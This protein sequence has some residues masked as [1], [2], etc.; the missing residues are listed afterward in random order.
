MN[1]SPREIVQKTLQFHYP[2]RIARDLWLL[3]VAAQQYPE[4][5]KWLQEKYPSDFT[6]SGY[7]YPPSSQVKGDPHKKG[8]FRDEWGCEFLNLQEGIIGEVKHPLISDIAD[9][10]KVSP[11]YEQLPEGNELQRAYDIITR[12]YDKTDNFMMANICPRPWERYQFLRGSQ[13]SYLDLLFPQ[14]GFEKLLKRINDFYLR[15]LEIWVKAKVDGISFMDDWGAQSTLLI[16]PE[17]WRHYFK[18]IY[19]QYCQMAKA[20]GKFVFMHSDGYIQDILPD[21]VEIGVDAV[22]SQLFCMDIDEIAQSVKGK[23]T[24]WGEIDRQHILP[25]PDPEAGCQAVRLLAEKLLLPE[26]GIIAQL[27]FGAGANPETVKAVYKEWEKY[28]NH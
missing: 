3:P 4:T 17:M 1:S 26:G 20:K 18:P 13:N 23:V 10:E 7:Y 15:E 27:E 6:G 12:N 5:V 21:L 16:S 2:E 11:P 8:F 19:R 22:N 14:Q 25:D 24:F 28:N 9:W